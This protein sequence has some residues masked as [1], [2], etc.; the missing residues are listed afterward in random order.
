M[1]FSPCF[2]LAA[3][4]LVVSADD[5]PTA[6]PYTDAMSGI[7]FA[8]W[9]DDAKEGA[10]SMTKSGIALST[11][12]G[13]DLIGQV[14]APISA[15]GW[16]SIILGDKMNGPLEVVAWPNGK[17]VVL[18]ARVSTGYKVSDTKVYSKTKVTLTPIAKGTY[19]N[20]THMSA[21]F[22][23]T[24]CLDSAVSFTKAT[25]KATISWGFTKNAVAKPSDPT[26]ALSDHTTDGEPYGNYDVDLKVAQQANFAQWAAMAGSGAGT[27]HEHGCRGTC[28]AAEAGLERLSRCIRAG[29]RPQGIERDDGR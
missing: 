28:G 8:G 21:T 7:T 6:A 15:S 11:D 25:P 12:S 13:T 20:A 23:C 18:G 22:L 29:C 2:A 10:G 14:I 1:F 27:G 9:T 4:T 3:L 16:A 24:G 17:S 5:Y 26:S 19:I